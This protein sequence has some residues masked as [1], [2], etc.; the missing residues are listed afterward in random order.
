MSLNRTQLT[1][2]CTWLASQLRREAERWELGEIRR[3]LI[4]SAICLGYQARTRDA[5]P[6][7]TAAVIEA[8]VRI[9]ARA[10]THRASALLARFGTVTIGDLK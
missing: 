4:H 10:A 6:E 2:R 5:A 1:T 8:A 9:L 3:E 7:V